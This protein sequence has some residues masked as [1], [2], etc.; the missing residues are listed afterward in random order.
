MSLGAAGMA[1]V[2][3]AA[4]SSSRVF[5]C[6]SKQCL[7]PFL[8]TATPQI[9]QKRVV[10]CL[11][12]V[13]DTLYVALVL[14][15]GQPSRRQVVTGGSS[16]AVSSR[17]P[18]RAGAKHLPREQVGELLGAE[19]PDFA[20]RVGLGAKSEVRVN[21]GDADDGGEDSEVGVG[22]D[23]NFLEPELVLAALVVVVDL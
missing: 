22:R 3:L 7:F 1:D 13:H 11:H 16:A 2:R 5:T 19:I 17:L 9:T 6:F 23:P 8:H 18:R 14:S 15:S 4:S 10:L 12:S 20:V 21:R